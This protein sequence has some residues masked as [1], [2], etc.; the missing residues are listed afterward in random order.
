VRRWPITIPAWLVAVAACYPATD[1][2]W[3]PFIDQLITQLETEAKKNPPASIWRYD[4]KGLLV[5]YIPPS[6]CDVPGELY[7]GDGDL[8]CAPDGGIGG[9]GDGR[10]PDFFS[11]RTAELL[12]WT[13]R[14]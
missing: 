1:E 12:V 2:D 4:Y 6:C 14:R 9:D 8:I 3:P 13:D 7:T 5:F 11:V 10:C